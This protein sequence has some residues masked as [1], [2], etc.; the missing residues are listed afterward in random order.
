[1]AAEE[2]MAHATQ[3][4]IN[5]HFTEIFDGSLRRSSQEECVGRAPSRLLKVG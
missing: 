2:K 4:K 3:E 1:M 5:L